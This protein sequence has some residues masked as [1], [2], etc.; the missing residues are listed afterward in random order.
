MMTISASPSTDVESISR[1]ALTVPNATE[2]G[3]FRSPCS[4]LLLPRGDRR[5][6]LHLGPLRRSTE[7]SG[8]YHGLRRSSTALYCVSCGSTACCSQELL[9]RGGGRG[10]R[11]PY[12]A[13]LSAIREHVDDLAAWLAIWENRREPDAPARRCA[14]GAVDA[15]DAM[16]GH[17]YGVRAQLVSEFRRADDATAARADK[18]LRGDQR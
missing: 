16:L 11:R 3:L 15:L 9:P 12:D 13:A 4:Q 8:V 2:Q 17:L 18:L 14:N 7:L 1:N 6:C 5:R 10:D